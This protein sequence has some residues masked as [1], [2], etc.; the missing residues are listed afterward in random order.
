MI[1]YIVFADVNFV[2]V[3]DFLYMA[4]N[5]GLKMKFDAINAVYVTVMD[6]LMGK[7]EGLCGT[8]NNNPGGEC[9]TILCCKWLCV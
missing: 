6:N 9:S 5:I 7:T 1:I 2:W 8:Y 4:T 3:G